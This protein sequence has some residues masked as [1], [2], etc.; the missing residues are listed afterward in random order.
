[1]PRRDAA[2]ITRIRLRGAGPRLAFE[3]ELRLAD[4]DEISVAR[5]TPIDAHRVHENAVRAAEILDHDA[6]P[7]ANDPG[8]LAAHEV[9]RDTHVAVGT[10]ADQE[11]ARAD[12]VGTRRV[13]RQADEGRSEDRG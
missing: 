10:S 8:V 12:R 3:P 11:R 6:V 2:S 1:M 9:S 5:R 7:L 4:R 13:A